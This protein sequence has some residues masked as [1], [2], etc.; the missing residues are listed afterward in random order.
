[1]DGPPMFPV[2]EGGVGHT[3]FGHGIF[4][5]K[6]DFE[7][8]AVQNLPRMMGGRLGRRRHLEHPHIA[9]CRLLAFLEKFRH[10]GKPRR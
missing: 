2:P 5:V 9:A 7:M 8:T 3:D 6:A 4:L 1:M 10:P